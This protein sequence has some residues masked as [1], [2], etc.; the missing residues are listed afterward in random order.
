MRAPTLFALLLS[1]PFLHLFTQEESSLWKDSRDDIEDV[2]NL[3]EEKAGLPNA[4]WFKRDR[5]SAEKDIEKLLDDVLEVFVSTRA[6][7]LR[8]DYVALGERITQ[9][10]QE[11]RDLRERTVSAPAEVSPLEFYKKTR[12]DLEEEIDARKQDIAELEKAR[13]KNVDRLRAEFTHLGIRMSDEQLRFH[14][15]TASGGDV[16]T[17]GAVFQN[18]REFN[19][20]LEQLMQRDPGDTEAARRYYGMHVV[21]IRTLQR[22]HDLTLERI[23]EDYLPR[24]ETL[25]E[26]ND[27]LRKQTER[28][29]RFAS[30][31]EKPLL[32]ASLR[33]QHTTNEAIDLYRQHLLAMRDEVYE[34]QKK[35]QRR[36]EVALNAF[37]TIRVSAMLMREMES[38][39]KDLSTLRDLNLPDLIPINDAAIRDKFFDIGNRLRE[40]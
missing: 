3:E 10:R 24:L 25:E 2:L 36:Y 34:A 16:M 30:R 17:L 12:Q 27:R 4:K 40:E 20:Q 9:R 13:E 29:V 18:V 19:A 37:H 32:H 28:M 26:E 21:L 1:A 7:D 8:A 14:L 33:T 15:D 5:K 23:D 31:D 22:A 6:T 38:A 35:I 39:L 11:I